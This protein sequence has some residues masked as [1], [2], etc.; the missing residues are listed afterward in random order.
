M[1]FVSVGKKGKVKKSET[2]MLAESNPAGPEEQHQ[3]GS[4]TNGQ[5]DFGPPTFMKPIQWQTS[6]RRE[7][8]ASGTARATSLVLV[9]PNLNAKVSWS[10]FI[11]WADVWA[12][13]AQ[14]HS[15][16]RWIMMPS[17]LKQLQAWRHHR[18]L[19]HCCER[20]R[21]VLTHC[22]GSL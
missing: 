3:E 9:R 4:S 2:S 6:K 7:L 12:T 15:Q 10:Q 11:L 13:A 22:S 5:I 16:L 14:L 19:S 8:H 20:H 17:G 18:V 1:S 21:R